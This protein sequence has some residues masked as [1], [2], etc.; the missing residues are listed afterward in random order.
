[1]RTSNTQWWALPTLLSLVAKNSSGLTKTTLLINHD[2]QGNLLGRAIA[3]SSFHHFADYNWDVDL[4]A[5]SFVSEAPGEGMKQNP[6]ALQ[7]IQAY[8]RNL[9]FWLTPTETVPSAK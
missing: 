4:G 9:A 1:L 3:Q 8:V 5:P 6:Q 2:E 7:D